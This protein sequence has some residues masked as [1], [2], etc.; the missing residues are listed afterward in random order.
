MCDLSDDCGDNYDEMEGCSQQHF[1]QTSFEDDEGYFEFSPPT[2]FQWQR[3]TGETA[4][5][6]NSAVFDHT[7]LDSSG[8][9]MFINSSQDVVEGETAE[10]TS[11]PFKQGAGDD[12]DCSVTFFYHM[13]GPNVGTLNVSVISG[14]DGEMQTLWGRT[15]NQ[16]NMW[17]RDVVRVSSSSFRSPYNIIFTASIGG[18]HGGDIAVDDVVFNYNCKLLDDDSTTSTT[19]SQN[20]LTNCDFE[21]ADLCGWNLDL[22]LN[23][24]D[25][26]HFER[27]NGDQNGPV[28]LP[29]ED[30]NGKGEGTYLMKKLPL[31]KKGLHFHILIFFF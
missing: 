9:Y 21:D 12:G 6:G 5:P 14:P 3:R 15:G 17:L 16:K 2:T 26:F 28:F 8:H 19:E 13:Y 4:N 24:T 31:F 1:L 7:T 25:R 20:K 23:N 22:E 11:K 10:L 30:H 27:R 29:T 18:K